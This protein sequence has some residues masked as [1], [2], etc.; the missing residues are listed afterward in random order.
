MVKSK[1]VFRRQTSYS[2]ELQ[3]IISIP[4]LSFFPFP[5]ILAALRESKAK[6][7]QGGGAMKDKP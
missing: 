4:K 7:L 3:E 2:I 1:V 6:W 5:G